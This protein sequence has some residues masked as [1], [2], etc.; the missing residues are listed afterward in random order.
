MDIAKINDWLQVVG[1]FGVIASLLFVGMQMKQTHEITL[2]NT[3]N[4]IFENNCFQYEMGFLPEAHW[5][6][7]LADIDC[8]MT[9]PFFSAIADSWSA[10]ESFRLVLDA[11]IERG[12]SAATSC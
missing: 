8:R 6:K 10:R 4:T 1:I 11:S 3:Y 7:N 12:R 9:E 5:Q 2:A